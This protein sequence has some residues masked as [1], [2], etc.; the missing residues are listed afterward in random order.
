MP[1]MINQLAK[2]AHE[3]ATRIGAFDC[4][5]CHGAGKH[6]FNGSLFV[7]VPCIGCKRTGKTEKANT[8]N[9]IFEEAHELADS[10]PSTVFSK[11]SEQ[12]E[13]ADIMLVCMSYC[14]EQGY[15]V[16]KI[17]REKIEYNKTR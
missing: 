12:S 7:P 17:L 16:E 14:V 3:Y 15:D 9:K 10:N 4:P 5:T 8:V 13:L 1:K 6:N 11:D 2:Q